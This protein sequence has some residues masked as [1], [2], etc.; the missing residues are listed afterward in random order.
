MK[1][2]IFDMDGVLLDSSDAW[3]ADFNMCLKR[4]RKRL[5]L[6]PEEFKQHVF[7]TASGEY[8]R[9][10]GFRDWLQ[11]QRFVREN[12]HYFKPKVRVE[13]N[14]DFVLK[15]LRTEGF[16]LALVSTTPRS[17]AS[18]VLEHFKLLGLLDAVVYGD[19][20]QASKPDPSGLLKACALLGVSPRD[21]LYVGDTLVDIEAARSAGMHVATVV[22]SLPR[23]KLSAADFVLGSLVELLS[24]VEKI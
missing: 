9:S 17:I 12:F 16:K 23:D 21:S 3:L 24:V 15:R 5:R 18:D 20:V 19:D 11:M 2:V 13:P 1:A 14:A 22:G 6:S 4:F 7:G 8:F 10:L